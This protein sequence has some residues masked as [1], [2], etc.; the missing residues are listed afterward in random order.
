MIG[1]KSARLHFIIRGSTAA[2]RNGS[3]LPRTDVSGL[4]PFLGRL[5][6]AKCRVS[7]IDPRMVV[8]MPMRNASL[9]VRTLLLVEIYEHLI[10][11]MDGEGCAS[12]AELPAKMMLDQ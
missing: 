4:G 8:M 6:S 12:A 2:S 1:M 3:Y 5:R 9:P 11:V 10:E 7:E